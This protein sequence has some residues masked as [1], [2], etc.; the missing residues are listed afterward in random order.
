MLTAVGNV[1]SEVTIRHTAG[2]D[3]VASFRMASNAR[4]FDRSTDRW[5]DGETA[6]FTVSCW[7]QLAGNAARSLQKGMPVVVFGRLRPREVEREVGEATMRTTYNDIEAYAL[8][9]DL[10]RGVATFERTKRRS[11]VESEQ[12]AVADALGA[13]VVSG[14]PLPDDAPFAPD[15]G[16]GAP[17]TPADPGEPRRLEEAP[18]A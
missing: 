9:P 3:S 1:V 6:F 8:G 4:R 7:R 16:A 14:L 5:V 11:V 13:A 17:E 2:G 18:A 10:S 15:R 12:R